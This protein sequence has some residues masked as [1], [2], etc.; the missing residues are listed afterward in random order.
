MLS[1][2]YEW[3]FDGERLEINGIEI[4]QKAGQGTLIIR[5]PLARHQGL[6]QCF[7]KNEF[8]IAVSVKSMLKKACKFQFTGVE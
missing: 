1:F 2:S 6:Y 7:A 4:V 3:T 8:G 5:E